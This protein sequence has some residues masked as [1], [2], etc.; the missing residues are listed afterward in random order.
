MAAY[1]IGAVEVSDQ[2]GM[3]EYA[4]KVG[5]TVEQAGGRLLAGG[6]VGEVLEGE[7]HPH[8]GGIIE[9]ETVED[10]KRWY[11][12]EE[13]APLRELRQRCGKTNLVV[14]QPAG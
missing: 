4:Q 13:Y 9:F 7:F 5:E 12:S 10:A 8:M 3:Q 2:D 14:L 1:V 11:E 6:P